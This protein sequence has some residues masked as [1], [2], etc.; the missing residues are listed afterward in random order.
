VAACRVLLAAPEAP[1]RDKM[2][3]ASARAI[4]RLQQGRLHRSTTTM[5]SRSSKFIAAFRFTTKPAERIE[6]TV[7]REIDLV[8]GMTGAAELF[9]FA[10][11]SHNAPESRLFADAKIEAAWEIATEERRPRPTGITLETTRAVVAGLNSVYW[12]C[13]ATYGSVLDPRGWVAREVPP[14]RRDRGDQAQAA[15]GGE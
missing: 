1:E 12:R 11:S 9:A 2:D 14:E 5:S 3:Q 7:E 8:H 6:R 13:P 10:R 4:A 15:S